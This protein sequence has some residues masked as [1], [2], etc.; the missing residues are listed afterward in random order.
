MRK[1]GH[2]LYGGASARSPIRHCIV[3]GRS[4]INGLNLKWLKPSC[5]YFISSDGQ[6]LSPLTNWEHVNGQPNETQA[7]GLATKAPFLFS[8]G[9]HSQQRAFL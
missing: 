8:D 9:G 2:L 1:I 4:K 7:Y 3:G 6:P 5:F